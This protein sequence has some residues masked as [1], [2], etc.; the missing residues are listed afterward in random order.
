MLAI[1]L[2]CLTSAEAQ[3]PEEARKFV[4]S[5]SAL[6]ETPRAASYQKFL[7]L[8]VISRPH[9]EKELEAFI[10]RA[11]RGESDAFAFVAMMV[12]QEYAGFRG[13]QVVGKL[14]L[15]R[16][17]NDGSSV[18][19]FFIGETFVR[20]GVGPGENRGELYLDSL[21]WYGV[22]AGMG[23]AKAH[24]RALEIIKVL[25]KDLGEEQQRQLH[26]LYNRGMEEGVANRKKPPR[27]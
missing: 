7:S 27:Q 24:D 19:A 23:E 2:A 12:W 10:Q 20:G 8:H 1:V 14:A 17:M 4:A 22:A 21:H 11:A 3:T 26:F 6:A 5:I 16:A 25:G 18:A 13:P 15:T 9:P